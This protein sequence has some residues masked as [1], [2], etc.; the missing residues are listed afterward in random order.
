MEHT[1][2]GRQMFGPG[3]ESDYQ[4]GE[5]CGGCTWLSFDRDSCLASPWKP[6]PR[7]F[8]YPLERLGVAE[9]G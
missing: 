9:N 1:I 4:V 3:D 2:F 8:C 5:H 6:V 7:A